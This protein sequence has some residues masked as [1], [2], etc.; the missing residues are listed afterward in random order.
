MRKERGREEGAYPTNE[1][2]VPAPL[3]T[4]M[5]AVVPIAEKQRD[6]LSHYSTA[7]PTCIKSNLG[8]PLPWY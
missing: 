4:L 7:H 1:K 8:G 6:Q 5:E 2:V 3:T